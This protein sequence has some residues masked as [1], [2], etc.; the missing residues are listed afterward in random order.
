[1]L[2]LDEPLS[3][4]DARVRL[5]LR[6]EI[7]MLQRRLGVTTIMVTHDQEEALTIA[8]RIVVMRE[9]AIEQVGTPREIYER[10]ATRFVADFV[11]TMNFLPGTMTAHDRVR[12]GGIEL[13]CSVNGV[14][15]GG[16]VTVCLRPEDVVVRG[17]GEATP[18]TFEVRIAG[19]EFM[20]SFVRARLTLEGLNGAGLT[21]DFSLNAVRDLGL[22][23]GASLRAALPAERL[24]IFPD[25][26][27]H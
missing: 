9:G 1:M 6:D 22:G 11:G 18:N 20:G 17:I 16:T 23:D 8:D 12:V 3:A 7:K 26:K 15:P 24:R 25:G 19:A 10:P 21:A 14:G 5:R 27:A 2:L 4:L 13:S